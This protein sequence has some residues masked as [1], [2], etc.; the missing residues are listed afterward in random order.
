MCELRRHTYA[1]SVDVKSVKR[2]VRKTFKSCD[3]KE[4]YFEANSSNIQLKHTGNAKSDSGNSLG[5]NIEDSLVEDAFLDDLKPEDFD[6]MNEICN[7]SDS[8]KNREEPMAV[9]EDHMSKMEC[10]EQSDGLQGEGT[11]D[12]FMSASQ[13]ENQPC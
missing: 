9:A 2:L 4:R 7:Q 11:V 3:C 10:S 13:S 12:D 6:D 8:G 5:K 1:N